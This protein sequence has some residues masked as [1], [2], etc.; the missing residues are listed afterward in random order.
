MRPKETCVWRK[1]NIAFQCVN[2]LSS[3]KHGD[4]KIVV[5]ACFAAS[6]PEQLAIIKIVK[7]NVWKSAC[8]KYFKRTWVVQTTTLGTQ[9]V[10]PNNV[11]RERMFWMIIWNGHVLTLIQHFWKC[12]AAESWQVGHKPHGRT[13]WQKLWW[14]PVHSHLITTHCHIWNLLYSSCSLM[15]YTC[16]GITTFRS[17]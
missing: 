13:N 17:P 9:V 15:D 16:K 12:G 14:Q 10:L 4:D 11:L 7:E 8:E 1:K 2:L 5:W 6:E 3:V